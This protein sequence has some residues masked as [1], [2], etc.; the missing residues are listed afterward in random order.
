MDEEKFFPKGT[1]AITRITSTAPKNKAQEYQQLKD[2]L[3]AQKTIA[4]IQALCEKSDHPLR[5]IPYAMALIQCY[6]DSPTV[7]KEQGTEKQ[8]LISA[9]KEV[10]PIFSAKN[11]LTLF[12]NAGV[13]VNA[14]QKAFC[15]LLSEMQTVSIPVKTPSP[16]SSD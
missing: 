12:A 15:N 5:V 6:I 1:G 14:E 3:A 13:D 10:S 4:E 9:I 11:T 16:G 7:F 8:L 2:T